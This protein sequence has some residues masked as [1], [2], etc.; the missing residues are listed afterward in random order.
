M[1][2]ACL[3]MVIEFE[4]II[5]ILEVTINRPNFTQVSR[6]HLRL[7]FFIHFCKDHREVVGKDVQHVPLGRSDPSLMSSRSR[8]N[9]GGTVP[10][11]S[12]LLSPPCADLSN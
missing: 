6:N 4:A 11:G 8:S 3:G 1:L 9:T 10:G 2:L 7:C 12:T 5:P